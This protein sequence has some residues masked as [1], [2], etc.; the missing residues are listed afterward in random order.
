MDAFTNYTG[1]TDNASL[2]IALNQ[3]AADLSAGEL[4]FISLSL[5]RTV[6]KNGLAESVHVAITLEQEKPQS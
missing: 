5:N 3:L 6:T 4:N 1:I 2:T